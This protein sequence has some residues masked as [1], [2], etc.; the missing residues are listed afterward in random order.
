L[1]FAELLDLKGDG[2]ADILFQ[3]ASGAR[4]EANSATG[5]RSPFS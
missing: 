1:T 3:D 2:G 5:C 4:P